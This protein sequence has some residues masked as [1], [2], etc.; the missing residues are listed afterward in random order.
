MGNK[1]VL[2]IELTQ[3]LEEILHFFKV[4]NKPATFHSL[5]II[6]V[7]NQMIVPYSV[8]SEF[9]ST[10][11]AQL[12]NNSFV[13]GDWK[14]LSY[15]QCN[16]FLEI[17]DSPAILAYWCKDIVIWHLYRKIAVFSSINK[18]RIR[19][20]NKYFEFIFRDHFWFKFSLFIFAATSIPSLLLSITSWTHITTLPDKRKNA[21]FFLL[22][23]FV[24]IKCVWPSSWVK[25]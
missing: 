18:I 23:S 25:V 10:E 6:T 13:V 22:L 4:N 9:S 15:L 8:T 16:F 11:G 12:F 17:C 7:L 20:I 5:V 21:I 2:K 24:Q 3:N 14:K 19:M 1:V